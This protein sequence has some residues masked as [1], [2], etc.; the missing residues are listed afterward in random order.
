MTTPEDRKRADAAVAE[1]ERA[2]K[3]GLVRIG[4][5]PEA[6]ALLLLL[7]PAAALAGTML[8]KS[9]QQLSVEKA[10]RDMQPQLQKWKSTYRVWADA[11]KRDD[12][13][14]YTWERWSQVGRE[15]GD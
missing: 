12:G 3:S 15:L 14:V 11:G 4:F 10:F 6:A 5:T 9:S 7:G 13:S 8:F 1:L 2:Y